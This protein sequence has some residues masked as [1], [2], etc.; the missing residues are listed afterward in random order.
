MRPRGALA[1]ASMTAVLATAAGPVAAGATLER[2]QRDGLVRCAAEER[3]GFASIEDDR[4]AG[5]AI[6]LCRALAMAVLGPAGRIEIRLLDS[7]VDYA[8]L[9]A[10]AFDIAFLTGGSVAEHALGGTLLPLTPVYVERYALLV[11][12]DPRWQRL[13]D[14]DGQTVCFMIGTPAQRALERSLETGAPSIARLGFEEEV[15]M[16]DA[17]NAGRCRAV[18][19]A[20]TTLADMR[21]DGGVN[22]LVSKILDVPLGIAPVMAMTGTGD[23]QWSAAAA[24]VLQGLIGSAA[25]GSGWQGTATGLDDAS[26]PA[27]GLR[28]HWAVE[29]KAKLGTYA[30]MVRRTSGQ[31]S[32]LRLA[33]G[34]NAP[35]PTGLLLPPTIE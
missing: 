10:G 30:D 29:I 19:D 18:A 26:A 28:P 6:E 9:K 2:V 8:G 20:A 23:G 24:W 33:P 27:L 12:D 4:A 1:V 15:E 3:P 14:L 25:A 22:H 7:E 16:R 11:P 34:P 21:Q 13:Q 17:Y 5:L 35:W 31:E 32:D